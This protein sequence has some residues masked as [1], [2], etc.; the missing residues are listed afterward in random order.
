MLTLTPRSILFMASVAVC[1]LPMSAQVLTAT[2]AE[3]QRTVVHPRSVVPKA[4][5]SGALDAR[6]TVRVAGSVHPYARPEADAGAVEERRWLSHMAIALKPD[7]EQQAALDA[8][9]EAVTDPESPLYH[10]WL[11]AEEYGEHFGIAKADLH[12]VTEWLQSQGFQVDEIPAGRS[13]IAFSG[14]AGQ[15]QT[16]F[17][18]PLRYFKRGDRLYYANAAEPQ[19]PEALGGMVLH[20]AGLNDFPVTTKPA[21]GANPVPQA[22]SSNGQHFLDPVDFATIY[23]VT[24]LYNSGTK[25]NGVKIAVIAPCSTD[26]SVSRSFWSLEHLEQSGTWYWYYGGT[27]RPCSSNETSEAYLDYQ[28]AGAIAPQAQI[29]LVSSNAADALYGAVSGV[30]NSK[31]APVITMS[32]GLCAS[33]STY[34]SW[35]QL[36]QQ[37]HV[38]GITGLVSSGDSGPHACGPDTQIAVNGFCH[39][40][41]VT[42]V[43]GTQFQ[44]TSNP[45]QYWS[46][47]GHAL[48]YIPEATWNEGEDATGGGYSSFRAKPGWQTGN[49]YTVRGVPDIAFTSAGHDAYRFC[50]QATTCNASYIYP[51]AGTSAASPA[52]AGIVALLIQKTG[53]WQGSLNPTLYALAARTDLGTIFHDVTSGN[54]ALTGEK[55]YAAGRG[56]DPVTGLGSIDAT[57]L[58]NNWPGAGGQTTKPKFANQRV[59]KQAPPSGTC[60]VPPAMTSFHP[61]DS[62]VYLYFEATVTTADTLSVTWIAPSGQTYSGA[63]WSSNSGTF[64]FQ[65]AHLLVGGMPNSNLG[66]WQVRV[67]D[68]GSPAFSV[69]FTLSR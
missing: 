58:V 43:G 33:Q 29:W 15:V 64:C 7:D 61:S 39:S 26:V 1:Q 53:H 51:I 56:W 23:N 48:G 66:A 9:S 37:A 46:T 3:S 21:M 34:N 47:A 38:S 69:P 57:A 62:T 45:S 49:P 67:S 55:G 8:F 52:F 10:Q 63:S 36:W 28:W 24:P 65:G 44:D 11:S 17:R 16:A 4:H 25:G 12:R 5:L 60:A 6:R 41:Y 50:P 40:E 22:V 35:V 18:T 59:T 19:V 54:N 42:C 2:P 68:S 32:Y 30:V 31:F 14:T 13:S 27:P 20:V